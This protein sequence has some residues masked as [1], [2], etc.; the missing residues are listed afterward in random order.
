MR[1]FRERIILHAYL[2]RLRQQSK[3]IGFVPTMGALHEGHLSLIREAASRCDIVV[4]SIFVNPTQFNDPKDYEKY[5][6]RTPEDI[7]KLL[8]SSTDALFLPS[9]F[10]IYGKERPGKAI[11]AL[12]RLETR[13]E[14]AFRPG[15][16]Q[17]VAQVMEQ[18]LQIVQPDLLFMGEKDYQQVLIVRELTALLRL[19]VSVISCPT[20]REP[21]G[22]AMSSRNARLSATARKKASLIYDTLVFIR[23]NF[24]SIPFSKLLA[25]GTAGLE[26]AGF[27]VE[28][29]AITDGK[30]LR[31]LPAPVAGP[32]VCLAAAWLDGVRLIDNMPL[33]ASPVSPSSP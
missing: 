13:W 2:G 14:G 10:G 8:E 27:K 28:Y 9:V 7:G 15:H 11:Y 17:G 12:S 25:T 16:F 31:P 5:P 30:D 18:L 20:R 24:R 32:M 19:P 33:T 29:L 26:N 23:D 21:D 6:V 22:L 4:C 3:T 1:I